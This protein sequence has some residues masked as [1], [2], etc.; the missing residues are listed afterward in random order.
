M[1]DNIENIGFFPQLLMV[2]RRPLFCGRMIIWNRLGEKK[3]KTLYK[4]KMKNF[5]LSIFLAC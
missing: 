1:A 2:T 3:R 4:N 5:S